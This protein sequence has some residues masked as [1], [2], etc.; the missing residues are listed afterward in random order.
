MSEELATVQNQSIISM[1]TNNASVFFTGSL[2]T[3]ADKVAF[4]NAT[5]N[6]DTQLKDHINEKIELVNFFCQEIE[7]ES[8]TEPGAKD[9]C[10]RI[11]LFAADGTTYACVSFGVLSSLKNIL[12][13]FGSPA[14]WD[15]P[16]TVIPKL[17]NKGA[18]RS[19]LT[20][21]IA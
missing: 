1:D 2:D 8:Q 18:D 5:Q 15:E 12:N 10:P 17:I 19:V 21:K 20:L 9:K 14:T 4:F 11:I 7:C 3:Q 6:P 13:I 16:L